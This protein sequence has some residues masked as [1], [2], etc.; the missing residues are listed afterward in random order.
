MPFIKV[1]SGEP[2]AKTN[3]QKNI[4]KETKEMEEERESKPDVQGQEGQ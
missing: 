3:N 2:S 4:A 1:S